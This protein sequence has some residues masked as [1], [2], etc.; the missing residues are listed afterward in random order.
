VS[1]P[2]DCVKIALWNTFERSRKTKAFTIV[3]SERLKS[4]QETTVVTGIYATKSS[5]DD[6]RFLFPDS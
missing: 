4:V 5:L 2:E 3:T 1:T 6:L